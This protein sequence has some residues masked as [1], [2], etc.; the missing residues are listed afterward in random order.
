MSKKTRRRY[1]AEYKEEAVKL[2]TEEGYSISQA[3]RNLDIN[4]NLL[5][6]WK[7]DLTR[8]PGE[9]ELSASEKEELKQLRA[10]VHQLKLE[11]EILKKATAFFARE[12]S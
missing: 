9:D 5:A 2:V 8:K 11:K 12:S 6:R 10:E 3:A 7:Q 4:A 1:T